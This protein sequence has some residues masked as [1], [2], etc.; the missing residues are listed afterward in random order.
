MVMSNLEKNGI[1]PIP[2]QDI[3]NLIHKDAKGNTKE[4]Q[5]ELQTSSLNSLQKPAS[6]NPP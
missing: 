4:H 5:I 2:K 6:F 3:K 1:Y